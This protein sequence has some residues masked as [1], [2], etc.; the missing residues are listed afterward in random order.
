ML[1]VKID[2]SRRVTKADGRIPLDGK[3]V[4]LWDCK[5]AEKPVDLQDYLDDQFDGYM[6]KEAENLCINNRVVVISCV[7]ALD[8]A[9]SGSIEDHYPKESLMNQLLPCWN[10]ITLITPI[11]NA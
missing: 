11:S 6:R 2:I 1:K 8:L 5:S 4:I 3:R 9:H 10:K 7:G